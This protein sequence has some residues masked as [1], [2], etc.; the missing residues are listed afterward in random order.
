MCSPKGKLYAGFLPTVALEIKKVF[1]DQVTQPKIMELLV[2]KGL[3]EE[4]FDFA[5]VHQ[6][7][8]RDSETALK[9][10]G[11]IANQKRVNK[12]LL[13]L[14]Q[15]VTKLGHDPVE[16]RKVATECIRGALGF[17]GVRVYTV[18]LEKDTWFHHYSEGEEGVSRF[19]KPAVP[20][21]NS[22]KAFMLKLLK[23]GVSPQE[24]ERAEAEGLYEWKLNGNWGYFYI[25]D[26]NQCDFVDKEQLRRDELGD[27]SQERNGVGEGA[28][29][30]ILYLVFGKTGEEKTEVYMIT[31]WGK[32]LPLFENKE[33]DLE[34]LRAFAA[35]VA[36]TNDLARA[37]QKV[38]DIS[39]RDELTKVYNR[40][41][42]N[43]KI[44]E[45]FDRA[46]R[47]D[48]PLSLLMI[49]IDHF[50]KF[51]DTYGHQAGDAVLATVAKTLAEVVRGVDTVARFGG[52]EFA[53]ILPETNGG[54][55][56][57]TRIAER[58]RQAIEAKKVIVRNNGAEEIEVNVTISVG[59]ATYKNGKE[60]A[61]R[62]DLIGEADAALY[63]AKDNGR[64][65]IAKAK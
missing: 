23:S 1:P 14:Q 34:L 53:V 27:A 7:L 20:E 48:H 52:E 58:L 4:D 18:D 13:V 50:K 31:N 62:H 36:R 56:S 55:E 28:A 2:E 24:I 60:I 47:F 21:E 38:K 6:A 44:R 35:S 19:T 64:N 39:V 16:N 59:V 54:K 25:P 51:N 5:S 32:N 41:Y 45:E 10:I 63:Q 37:H 9:V 15:L 11:R 42:F 46:S 40:R 17:S 61:S 49:D 26:R 43:D 57:A 8:M 22:E 65:Q 33:N 30:E 12:K 29:K 3:V